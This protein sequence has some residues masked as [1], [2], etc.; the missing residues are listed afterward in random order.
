MPITI[1]GAGCALVDYLYRGVDF[2]S[3]AVQRLLSRT[4]GDGGLTIG[5]LVFADALERFSGQ[6]IDAILASVAPAGTPD[7]ANAGGPAIVSLIHAAQL[8]PDAAVRFFGAVGSDDAGRFLL[9]TAAKTPLDTSRVAVRPGTTPATHVFSDPGYRG[10]E[11]ERLFVN[12]LGTAA[13]LSPAELGSDFAQADIVQLGGTA[14]VPQLHAALPRLLSDARRA[15]ALTVVNTVYDFRA[16]LADPRARWRLGSDEAYE[17][18][19]LLVAD[20][21]EA[22]R[23]SGRERP[24][25]AVRWFLEQGADAAVVTDG[26][27]PVW[28]AAAGRRFGRLAPRSRPALAEYA[29]SDEVVHAGG[30]T[31]GCGDTFAGGLVASVAEQLAAGAS[32]LDL[33]PAIGLAIAS[34]AFCLTHLGGTYL[35]GTTGEKR[36]RVAQ[37]A[38]RVRDADGGRA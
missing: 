31:T 21:E 3:P 9:E 35:E 7:R 25:A 13:D 30:D 37:L 11:G 12:V 20:A 2:E 19:D 16:E 5:G 33:D 36:E 6:Q 8:L 29:K 1:H 34:G 22:R 14:L 26:P 18:T 10:G 4:P 27:R 15:G 38:R 17:H 23:L 32:R 24:D 28:Y